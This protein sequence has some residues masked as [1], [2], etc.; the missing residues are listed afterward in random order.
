LRRRALG[1]FFVNSDIEPTSKITIPAV[2]I[3]T[4][5]EAVAFLEEDDPSPDPCLMEVSTVDTGVDDLCHI[6]LDPIE[7]SLFILKDDESTGIV[8]T[9]EESEFG[10]FLLDAVEW[11]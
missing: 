1:Q 4:G 5:D 9:H 3:A 6:A 11:L 8:D 7:S 10:E 2:K